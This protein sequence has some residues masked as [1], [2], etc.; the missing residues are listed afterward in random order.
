MTKYENSS[1][2]DC[3]RNNSSN[4][5]ETIELQ[6]KEYKKA[7]RKIRDEKSK[8]HIHRSG[9]GILATYLI[10]I[11]IFLCLLCFFANLKDTTETKAMLPLEEQAPLEMMNTVIAIISIAVSVWI[12]LNIYNV[13]KKSDIDGSIIELKANNLKMDQEYRKRKFLS[14]LEKT[15]RRYEASEYLYKQFDYADDIS[16]EIWEQLFDIEKSYAEC[17]RAYE[18]KELH[19]GSKY[20]EEID[21]R[22][23]LNCAVRK[24]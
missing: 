16:L 10:V 15:E 24:K 1:K 22:L 14:Q 7:I 2:K 6:K 13:Y 19:I 11:P 3:K 21:T 18:E 23:S 20:A 5:D 8:I 4:T 17:C 12:G 9:V